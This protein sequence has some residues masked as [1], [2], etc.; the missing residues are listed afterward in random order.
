[1]NQWSKG[2]GRRSRAMAEGRVDVHPM[3]EMFRDIRTRLHARHP[4]S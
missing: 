4:A 1:M 3:Q 2:I